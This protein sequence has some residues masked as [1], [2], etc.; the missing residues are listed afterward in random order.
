M[1]G[2][3]APGSPES[4]EPWTGEDDDSPVP[5][6]PARVAPDLSEADAAYRRFQQG[7]PSSPATAPHEPAPAGTPRNRRRR[8]RAR[9]TGSSGRRTPRSSRPG[10]SRG[11][12][13][14]RLAPALGVVIALCAAVIGGLVQW[15]GGGDEDHTASPTSGGSAATGTP[16]PRVVAPSP[17]PAPSA[18]RGD[19]RDGQ[20]APELLGSGSPPAGAGFSPDS[21]ADGDQWTVRFPDNYENEYSDLVV[22]H[23]RDGSAD[24]K[25][26]WSDAAYADE[27]WLAVT[28]RV[29]P[30]GFAPDEYP[31]T[32]T[33]SLQGES[34]RW[35]PGVPA[36]YLDER[37][38]RDDVFLFS[39]PTWDEP[40]HPVVE[41]APRY[42][43]GVAPVY[44][45][46]E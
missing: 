30:R 22:G 46:V 39:V 33:L 26:W 3:F 1:T 24:V 36:D 25:P 12:R 6:P 37:S 17:A 18:L 41:V 38:D 14:L 34:G 7:S 43:D 44:V 45:D 21:A 11:L 40:R 13:I 4:R 10:V 8:R 15:F 16:T 19:L 5:T 28:V 2:R 20:D 27:R 32:F 31:T 42:S 35:Y 29:M 9:R 23:L